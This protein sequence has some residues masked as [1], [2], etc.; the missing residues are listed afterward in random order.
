MSALPPKSDIAERDRHLRYVPITD[1]G[2]TYR[3]PRRAI[4]MR[5]SEILTLT[6]LAVIDL[7]RRS[8]TK[9]EV[10]GAQRRVKNNRSDLSN[11]LMCSG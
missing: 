3:S 6:G 11:R 2:P 10:P 9:T 5:L 7:H 8:R 1:I 4:D